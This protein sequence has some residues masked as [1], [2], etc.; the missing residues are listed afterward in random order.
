MK[1]EELTIDLKRTKSCLEDLKKKAESNKLELA[2]RGENLKKIKIEN[3]KISEE[4]VAQ[5]YNIFLFHLLFVLVFATSK[6]KDLFLNC[7]KIQNFSK[8]FF[9]ITTF[10]FDH[11]IN[12]NIFI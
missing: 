11:Q 2:E 10:L 1:T 12:Q 5:K 7:L 8:L 3:K 9:Y 4:L 6:P